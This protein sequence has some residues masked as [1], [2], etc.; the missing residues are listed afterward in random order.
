MVLHYQPIVDL[1]TGD[2]V[3]LEALVRWQH[4]DYGLLTPLEFIPLA[5]ELGVISQIGGWAIKE[6]CE[7]LN[8]W[9]R[10]YEHLQGLGVSVNLSISQVRDHD[11]VA[12]TIK[13]VEDSGILPRDLTLEVTESM[14]MTEPEEMI[15][16]IGQLRDARISVA[17]DDFGIGYSSLV[18]VARLRL[19]ALKID[20]EFTRSITSN[21]RYAAVTQSIIN[22][23]RALDLH[24]TA[25]GVETMDQLLMLQAL[26]CDCVQ[27]YLVARP[28]AA[29]IIE[30]VLR[31]GAKLHQLIDE[32]YEFLS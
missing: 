5:E 32:K 13:T 22:L 8:I 25:E 27:G 23:G 29:A 14:M 3:R 26:G 9:Q 2:I 20:R 17:V 28:F 15:A 7:Q 24:I 18:Y 10:R 19:N 21:P 11:F 30:P 6:A 4:P 31:D 1:E 12:D 16:R